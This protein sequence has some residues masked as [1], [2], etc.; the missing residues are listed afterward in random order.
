[1]LVASPRGLIHIHHRSKMACINSSSNT[2]TITT[3]NTTI[4]TAIATTTIH[5]HH[6]WNKEY[7]NT[8]TAAKTTIY[9]HLSSMKE[10]K[11]KLMTITS[12]II[13]TNPHIQ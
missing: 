1:M 11:S 2:T 12:N 13:R 6:S 4:V 3:M 9:M 7:I 5:I 8:N 10:N